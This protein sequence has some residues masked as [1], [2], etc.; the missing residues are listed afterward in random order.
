VIKYLGSKRRLLP[1]LSAVLDDIVATHG[2]LHTAADLFSGTS[3]V[4]QLLKRRGL[5]VTANDHNAC[6]HTLARCYVE[7]DDDLVDDARALVAELNRLPGRPGW[8]TATYAEDARYLQ[9]K[10][11]A[12]VEAIRDE[13]ARKDLPPALHAVLLTSLI[14]AA[15]RVDSTV[16]VQMAYLK[17]WSKR[18]YN[19]LE[20]RVPELLPRSKNGAGLALREEAASAATKV[21]ADVV[22]LDPP[23]NQHS[24]LGNY[25]V[26]E[27]IA[28]WDS[29]EVYGI[30]RKRVDCQTRKSAFNRRTAFRAAFADVVDRCRC[31]AL[32]VSFSDEGCITADEMVELLERRGP[33]RVHAQ[34]YRR[35]VGAKIGIHNPRGEKVGTVSHT[36][37]VE[38]VFVVDVDRR[39][40]P[41]QKK[42]SG[43]NAPRVS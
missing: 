22:Y 17:S 15:D 41:A 24:Y 2:P 4:A 11:A 7:A 39:R 1:L 9:P 8:F 28:L 38:F 19:D 12:R 37:N 32:V 18:S 5:Q 35:Y 14:E 13:L 31:K 3:R 30:A 16:G 43:A 23:Y 10:N 20:L 25:H 27:T 26:W 40:K 21:E 36:D 29:P 33:V 6:A 34:D 42:R